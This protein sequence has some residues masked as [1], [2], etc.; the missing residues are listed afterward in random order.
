MYEKADEEFQGLAKRLYEQNKDT[1]GLEVHPDEVMFLRSDGK[2]RVHAYC[3]QIR[4]EYELL[5]DKKFF[6]V[7]VSKNFDTLTDKEKKY[8]ILHELKHLHY[9]LD[10]EKYALFKH[11]LENFNQLVMNHKW[12]LD[13]IKE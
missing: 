5:S 9:D 10:S 11:D 13:I 7:I 12:N 6:I 8:V 3:K 4:R 2:K 1:L